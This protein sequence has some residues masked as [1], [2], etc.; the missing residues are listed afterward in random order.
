MMNPDDR[1]E[2]ITNR[3]KIAIRQAGVLDYTYIKLRVL[4]TT[5]K[6]ELLGLCKLAELED[7]TNQRG[8]R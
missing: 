4:I 1:L 3:L 5:H 8:A 6:G 7:S 2:R